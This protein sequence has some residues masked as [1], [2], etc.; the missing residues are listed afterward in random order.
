MN[1]WRNLSWLL[2]L[3]DGSIPAIKLSAYR[4][5]LTP[6]NQLANFY[7]FKFTELLFVYV[8]YVCI[9]RCLSAEL[10]ISQVAP[11]EPSTASDKISSL[12]RNM[13]SEFSRMIKE[14][15]ALGM[16]LG[17]PCLNGWALWGALKADT[18]V[19]GYRLLLIPILVFL[20]F[21]LLKHEAMLKFACWHLS[22][23]LVW[24]TAHYVTLSSLMIKFF[25]IHSSIEEAEAQCALLDME[26][27]CVSLNRKLMI[28]EYTQNSSDVIKLLR[29]YWVYSV[30]PCVCTRMDVSLQIQMFFYLGQELYTV[31][32]ALVYAIH[33]LCK[34]Q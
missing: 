19:K 17:I 27:L 26:S 21:C 28:N 1:I 11:D 3:I 12:R 4:K 10:I 13:G 18:E 31:I 33:C 32:F 14:A 16:A 30:C 24:E 5:R 23:W 29:C 7:C 25:I 34:Q 20:L 15:K 8:S 9:Q 6:G 22:T 2:C